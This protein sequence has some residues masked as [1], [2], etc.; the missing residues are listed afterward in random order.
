MEDKDRIEQI[1]IAKGLNKVEFS[2]KTGIATASLSHM[3][4]GRSNPTLST[5][6]AIL[7]AFPDLNPEWVYDGIGDMYRSAGGNSGDASTGTSNISSEASGGD[8]ASRTSSLY[9]SEPTDIFANIVTEISG[10][11][12]KPQT[13]NIHSKSSSPIQVGSSL[14]AAEI[15]KETLMQ[16]HHPKRNIVEVRI[17]FDDGTYEAFSPRGGERK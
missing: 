12:R 9:S 10:D 13:S 4:S 2:A 8:S 11:T 1:M 6:R 14:S 7:K 15:V 5:F 3:S 17:F 16:M